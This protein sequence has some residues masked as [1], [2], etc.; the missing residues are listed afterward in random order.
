MFLYEYDLQNPPETG[1]ILF[2]LTF[3]SDE[4]NIFL[5]APAG[6]SCSAFLIHADFSTDAIEQMS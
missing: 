2:F 1:R 5:C 3:F 6:E 4:V